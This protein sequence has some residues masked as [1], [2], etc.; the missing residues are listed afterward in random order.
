MNKFFPKILNGLIFIVIILQAIIYYLNTKPS[1]KV[2]IQKSISVENFSSIVLTKSGITKIGSKKLNKIDE[3]NIY[4]EGSS[5]LENKD[6]KIYGINISIDM[7][8]EISSSNN[9]VEVINSMG[10]LNAK[11]FKNIDS[12]SKI[13]FKGEVTFKSHD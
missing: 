4:L 12:E 2:Y 5:Y 11:G 3:S 10:T 8:N 13:F 9:N 1:S 7:E 6:Y